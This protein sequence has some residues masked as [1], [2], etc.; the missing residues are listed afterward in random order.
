MNSQKINLKK[1]KKIYIIGPAGGGKTILA[2]KLSKELN[3]PYFELDAVK[4]NGKVKR[5]RIERL[6]K[7]N[8]IFSKNKTWIIEG[9]QYN[10]WTGIIWKNCDITIMSCPPVITRVFY[11]LKRYF[12]DNREI[13]KT[14]PLRDKLKNIKFSLGFKKYYL[15]EFKAHAKKHK[16]QIIN[17]K[18]LII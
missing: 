2:R 1:Y 11:L 4:W 3:Y 8:Y 17:A 13:Y 15:P 10:D 14:K 5:S 18:T 7:L 6:K 16:K 9:A 12:F